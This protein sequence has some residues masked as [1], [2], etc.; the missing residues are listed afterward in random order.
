LGH[1]HFCA[2]GPRCHPFPRTAATM[3][4]R[5]K[6]KS[7]KGAQDRVSDAEDSCEKQFMIELEAWEDGELRMVE[8]S[9]LDRSVGVNST[10]SVLLS[11]SIPRYLVASCISKKQ[12]PCRWLLHTAHAFVAH[13][14]GVSVK[15]AQ[16]PDAIT[17]SKVLCQADPAVVKMGGTYVSSMAV[18]STDWGRRVCMGRGVCACGI[19]SAPAR[20]VEDEHQAPSHRARRRPRHVVH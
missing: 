20:D 11:K 4:I 12:R 10:F 1:S 8:L 7:K 14:A 2:T 15:I 19:C 16:R 13:V 6:S 17:A 3:S 9:E 5:G 18:F